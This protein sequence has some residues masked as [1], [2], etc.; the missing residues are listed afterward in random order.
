MANGKWALRVYD[1]DFKDTHYTKMFP[2]K[3]KDKAVALF[4]KTV[5]GLMKR[6]AKSN[7]KVVE[8]PNTF[9]SVEL[10]PAQAKR[11]KFPFE[12]FIDFQGIKIDVE[13]AKGST[14]R[15]KGPEGEWSTFMHAHYGEIRGT[16]GTDGDKLDV[17]VGDNH[18]SSLVVVIHQH[19]PWDGKYDEDK[20]VIG[21]ESVEEAI[22][23]YKKQYDR[24]GFYKDKEHTAMPIGAF[25]R[26]V[27]DVRNKGKKVTAAQTMWKRGYTEGS[28]GDVNAAKNLGSGILAMLRALQW[29]Y[30]TSHWQIG[31]DS[32]YGDHLLFERLYDKTT[33]ETDGLAEKLVGTFGIA[34]VDAVEQARKMTFTLAVWDIGC[35]FERGL[36]AERMFQVALKDCLDALEGM[37]E[38]SLGMDDFLRTMANDHETHQYL[39]QQRQGGVR[40]AHVMASTKR[41]TQRKRRAFQAR[42]LMRFAA[43]DQAFYPDA[44][45]PRR[46]WHHIGGDLEASYDGAMYVDIRVKGSDSRIFIS[47]GALQ[48]AEALMV[49]P[50]PLR[51][52]AMVGTDTAAIYAID[53]GQL[54]RLIEGGSW[55]ESWDA[56]GKAADQLIR[57]HGGAVFLTGADG[58]FDV[59]IPDKEKTLPIVSEEGLME[60]YG[61]KGYDEAISK[62]AHQ[63]IGG[64]GRGNE[65]VGRPGRQA[66]WW[67]IG[68]GTTGGGIHTPPDYDGGLLNSNPGV[69]G[70]LHNGDGPAD[71]MDGA[72]KDIVKLYE[73]AWGRKPYMAELDGVW[74]FCANPKVIAAP[75]STGLKTTQ[76][77]LDAQ[78][79]TAA[80]F[81]NKPLTPEEV[82]ESGKANIWL[83]DWEMDGG[84]LPPN[85]QRISDIRRRLKPAEVRELLDWFYRT[86]PGG[87]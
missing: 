38:L 57:Q 87:F 40:M 77:A 7:A 47:K 84:K 10:Q 17:Y 2:S 37:G 65:P 36:K 13:N 31:G 78:A 18:D 81:D 8:V 67:S 80:R 34:A 71:V 15:G 4:D 44:N 29:N 41:A 49:N 75:T 76:D 72:I 16:E 74:S 85:I 54:S 82:K 79:K 21:C 33:E 61:T 43:R 35:P 28:P 11:K 69:D 60:P 22:G 26:W 66:G 14:R 46:T 73:E 59:K 3:D 25:W 51:M 24:P 55:K 20:V 5:K 30:L 56:D 42:C 1:R 58:S 12:G 68:D 23:L 19:N 48:A 39:L 52:A 45:D 32:S 27:N 50:N 70:G 63:V 6:R 53:P 64:L 83:M 9:H 62:L 86:A